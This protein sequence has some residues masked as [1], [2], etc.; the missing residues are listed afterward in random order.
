MLPAVR[1]ATTTLHYKC[2]T[3]AP[4]LVRRRKLCH[5]GRQLLHPLQRHAV[6]DGGAHAA[7]AA[8]PLELDLRGSGATRKGRGKARGRKRVFSDIA[9]KHVQMGEAALPGP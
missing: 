2:S 5:E 9:N 4:S 8:V 7:H 6:V 3:A 1:A